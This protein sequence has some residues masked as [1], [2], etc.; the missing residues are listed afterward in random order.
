MF[1]RP[2]AKTSN[3]LLCCK[4]A[5]LLYRV[6]E[7]DNVVFVKS[8]GSIRFTVSHLP[9]ILSRSHQVNESA[10]RYIDRSHIRVRVKNCSIPGLHAY[11]IGA[12]SNQNVIQSSLLTA[13]FLA[14]SSLL[15]TEFRSLNRR[16]QQKQ[17]Q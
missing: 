13:I 17:K 6:I 5:Q 8:A 7:Y 12:V 4:K 2:K 14:I 1:I 16:R 3:R 9:H 15:Y 10:L 11:S